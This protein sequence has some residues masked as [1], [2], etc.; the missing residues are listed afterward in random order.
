MK[1]KVRKKDS[2]KALKVL[3]K[4]IK[5]PLKS[6]KKKLKVEKEEPLNGLS[7]SLKKGESSKIKKMER[8]STGIS[9]LDRLIE[10]GFLSN[11]INLLVGSSGSS[12]SIFAMQFLMQAIKNGE[13]CL[14]ITFEEP[15]QE[16]YSNMLDFGWDLEKAEKQGKFT[17]LEYTPEKVKTM[18]DEGG[19]IIE[20]IVL[21]NNIK[22]LVIDSITSFELLF[23]EDLKKRAAALSLF[24]LLRKWSCTTLLTYEE[25]PL[26]CT[27]G[28]SRAL[29]FESDSIILLYFL[30]KQK[31]RERTI[32]ILKMRGT[33]HATEIYPVTID[34]KGIMVGK[35][36]QPK[37]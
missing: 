31:K 7:S 29:E 8:V 4:P 3:S 28:S 11:S 30:R 1:K 27:T 20:S 14:Y 21:K 16:F 6:I 2:R 26:K 9:N 19:G 35:K 24:R 10:G 22:R 12:K 37:K 32:E 15:R 34:K 33:N 36:S 5:T 25:D 17:F 18:L 13:N 23:E